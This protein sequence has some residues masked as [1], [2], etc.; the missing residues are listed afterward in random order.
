MCLIGREGEEMERV[1]EVQRGNSLAFESLIRKEQDKIYRIIFAYVQNE[2]DAIEVYQ[3]VVLRA[4]EKIDQLKEQAYYSTWMIRIAINLSITYMKKRNREQAVAPE[5]FSSLETDEKLMD[6]RI[7]LWQ[8][9]QTLPNHYKT[10]LLLRYYHDYTVPQIAEIVE[11]PIGTAKTHIRR[12]LQALRKQLKGA[13]NDE[14]AKS[15]EENVE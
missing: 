15:V 6:E 2:G 5:V 9:L 1:K 10:A 4:F 14:W 12:G 8:A 11:L 7:D 3:Q 13:Y